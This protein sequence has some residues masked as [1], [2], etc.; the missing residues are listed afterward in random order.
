SSDVCSSD[1]KA[2][3]EKTGPKTRFSCCVA[4]R[5]SALL[6]GSALGSGGLVV[7]LF[8]DTRGLARTLAQVVELGATD[9]T[10][11]LHFDA[12]HQRRVGLERTLDTFARRDLADDECGV[13]T[14]VAL[15]DD[16]AFEGL[17]PL[18]SAFLDLH[19]DD[20][21]VAGT[22]FGDGLAFRDAGHL[23]LFE[24]L[25]QVHCKNSIDVIGLISIFSNLFL[26][27]CFVD[28]NN[29]LKSVLVSKS[30]SSNSRLMIGS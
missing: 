2:V 20:H 9:V 23:F 13:E 7:Q 14:A 12:G 22:E 25:K 3:N 18:A 26:N 17:E 28:S 1:L 30:D 29:S 15:G 11:A 8:L 16:N 27:S 24:L 19:L 6:L 4:W 21:G 5:R 10:A